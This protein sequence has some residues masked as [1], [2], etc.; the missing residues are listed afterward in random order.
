MHKSLCDLGT[1]IHRVKQSCVHYSTWPQSHGMGFA[2]VGP[3]HT[4]NYEENHKMTNHS[5]G[6]FTNSYVYL[7]QQKQGFN[8]Y[9]WFFLSRIDILVDMGISDWATFFT[10]LDSCFSSKDVQDELMNCTARIKFIL[11]EF[12]FS[13]RL[14]MLFPLPVTWNLYII[15]TIRSCHPYCKSLFAR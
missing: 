1:A 4:Y 7:K 11:L 9:Y 13:V 6:T 5:K 2:I 3:N 15:I 10:C 14:W 8:F 12:F